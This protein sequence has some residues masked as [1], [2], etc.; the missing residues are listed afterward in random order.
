MKMYEFVDKLIRN[1]TVNVT[2]D[3]KSDNLLTR[4]L[5]GLD[6]WTTNYGG[7]HKEFGKIK[8]DKKENEKHTAGLW[9]WINSQPRVTQLGMLT[10]GYIDT[11]YNKSGAKDIGEGIKWKSMLWI[12][13]SVSNEILYGSISRL[14]NSDFILQ[15][16]NT[17]NT[18]PNDLDDL[19]N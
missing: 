17:N 6:F 7:D 19:I 10:T 8:A 14:N 13:D 5:T 11:Y 9:K 18:T 12:L 3:E 1:Y 15:K 2:G 16:T 4:Q